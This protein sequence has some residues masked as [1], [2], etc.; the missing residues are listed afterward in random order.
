MMT[1]ETIDI[2]CGKTLKISKQEILSRVNPKIHSVYNDPLKKLVYLRLMPKII[3]KFTPG[4]NFD[5]LADNDI[6]EVTAP[7][8]GDYVLYCFVKMTGYMSVLNGAPG[9]RGPVLNHFDR[10]A[11]ELFLNRLSDSLQPVLGNMGNWLRAAFCDS[12]ELEGANWDATMLNQFKKRHGYDLSPYLPYILF[13]VGKMGNPVKEKYG[14]EIIYSPEFA[15]QIER[16]RN[17]F[18]RTQRE[19]FHEGFLIPYVEWCHINGLKSRIQAYGRGLHPIESSMILDILENESWFGSINGI[20]FPENSYGQ[21]AGRGYSMI[22]KFVASGALIAGKPIISCEE[23]TNTGNVFNASLEQIKITGDMSNLSGVNHSILHGFNYSPPEAPFPGWVRYGTFFNERNS[24][25]PYVKHWID[26]KTR[27]SAVFQNSTLQSDIALMHPLEDMWSKIGAQRDPFP[28]YSYPQYAHN[29]WEAIHQAG[30]GCDCISEGLIERS[31]IND[32]K[33]ICGNRS[34]KTIILI[35]VESI[36][37]KSLTKLKDFVAQGG[38]MICIEKMPWKSHGLAH[39]E[40]NN[41]AVQA[42]MDEIKTNYPDRFICVD[43]PGEQPILEW[44][45]NIQKKMNLEPFI[46]NSN[47]NK[48]ISHNYY[49]TSKEDIF[50]VINYNMNKDWRGILEFPT[51]DRSKNAWLWDATTGK[52]Y[53][54]GDWE[55]GLKLR[56]EP[57]DSKLIVFDNNDGGELY[58]PII[59]SNKPLI[60]VSGEWHL[61]LKHG[62]TGDKFEIGSFQLSDFSKSDNLKLKNFAGVIEYSKMV[63]VNDPE[64]IK[65]IDAGTTSNVIVELFVNGKS[66]GVKWYGDRT[67]DV[68]GQLKKGENQIVFKATT[69]LGNYM[70][71]LKDNAVAQTWVKNQPYYPMG[72]IGPITLY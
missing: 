1:L 27:L 59:K 8:N 53:M 45:L 60:T 23:I 29:V 12:F 21:R 47:P 16:V 9:A 51:V 17:D 46:R 37:P 72:I 18:E 65:V 64:K 32:G 11:V 42:I 48:F 25:W 66:V 50:F 39:I 10:D 40:E 31:T 6:I 2:K 38:L 14:S 30:N 3:T 36:S 33:L 69:V 20:S 49:K 56:L 62:V 54:L 52:R 68:T 19:L 15:D 35:E 44:Y 24:W 70:K 67:F 55:S 57:S 61:S 13:K 22:N 4:I 28:E 58:N 41:A 71:S 26:Y 43:A 5:Q 63:K 7:K 34:Y